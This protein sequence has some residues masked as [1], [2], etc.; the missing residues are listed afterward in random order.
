[1]AKSVAST[2]RRNQDDSKSMTF[3]DL[4]I[5]VFLKLLLEARSIT[6][7]LIAYSASLQ[8]SAHASRFAQSYA[9]H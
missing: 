3:N 2:E 4:L 8:V 9:C 5:K 6:D 7:K 1:M